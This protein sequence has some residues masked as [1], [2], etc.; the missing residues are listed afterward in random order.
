MRDHRAIISEGMRRKRVSQRSLARAM[1]VNEGYFSDYLRKGSPETLDYEMRMK[2]AKMLD[3]EPALLTDDEEV[4]DSHAPHSDGEVYEPG[5]GSAITPQPHVL[6][7]RVT[8]HAMDD[9]SER[10]VP[11]NVAAFDSRINDIRKIKAG[12]IVYAERRRDKRVDLLIRQFLPPDKLAS[13]SSGANEMLRADD[14]EITI[15][16]AFL[17]VFRGLGGV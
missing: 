6:F 5:P 9:H 10:L 4:V 15:K 12:M 11:G 13:N 1:D 7:I 16:G 14:A 17:Y 2:I 3:I 8:S